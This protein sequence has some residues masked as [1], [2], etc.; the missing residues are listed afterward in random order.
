MR[1]GTLKNLEFRKTGQY[2]LPAGKKVSTKG[3]FLGGDDP[4]F[5]KHTTLNLEDFFIP[6]I[7]TTTL[8]DP[9]CEIY[10]IIS[11]GASLAGR[12]GKSP[13]I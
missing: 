4:L 5:G 2:I 6:G 13:G 1:S 9:G 7:L 11:P 10:F 3:P 8:P 12:K